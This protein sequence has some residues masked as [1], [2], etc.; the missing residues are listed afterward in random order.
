MK[1]DQ[2]IQVQGTSVAII[3]KNEG[4][5]VSLTDIARHKNALEP[6]IVVSNWFRSKNTIEY[7]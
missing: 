4:D 2:K 6:K 1:S 7:L 5:Y 3:Q